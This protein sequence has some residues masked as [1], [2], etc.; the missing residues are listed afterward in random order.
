MTQVDSLTRPIS[1]AEPTPP[2]DPNALTNEEAKEARA[3]WKT[4]RCTWCGG[5]HLRACPRVS[6]LE[7]GNDGK[8]VTSVEYFADGVWSD[9]SVVWPEDMKWEQDEASPFEPPAKG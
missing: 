8:T 2:P 4:N 3:A 6:K 9:A 1:F 5:L 7:F